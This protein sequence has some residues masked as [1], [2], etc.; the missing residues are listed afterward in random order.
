MTMSD[1]GIFAGLSPIVAGWLEDN[2]A[3]VEV[4]AGQVLFEE[5]TGVQAEIAANP[6][7]TF[8]AT[9]DVDGI[10]AFVEHQD[11]DSIELA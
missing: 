10:E 2:L 3:V 9:V 8:S 7:E 1:S 11:L 5:G 6:I 4:P